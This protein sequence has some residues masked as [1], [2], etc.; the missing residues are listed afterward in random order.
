MKQSINKMS[1]KNMKIHLLFL[2]FFNYTIIN[3][4]YRIYVLD[5]NQII[6]L[7]FNILILTYIIVN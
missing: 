6:N 5:I 1:I 7:C 2:S 3:L 4:N